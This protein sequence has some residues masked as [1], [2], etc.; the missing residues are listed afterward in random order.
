[1]LALRLPL[2]IEQRLEALAKKTGLINSYYAREAIFVESK[3]LRTT[4]WR[5]GVLRAAVR[6]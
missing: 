5:V 4:I 2:D 6:A 3:T 1:M